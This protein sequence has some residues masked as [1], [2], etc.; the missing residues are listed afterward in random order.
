[1][2][3]WRC[4]AHQVVDAIRDAPQAGAVHLLSN[5]ALR[6]FITKIIRACHSALYDEYVPGNTP[7]KYL[8][9]M[10]EFVHGESGIEPDPSQFLPQHQLQCK[11]IKDTKRLSSVDAIAAFNGKFQYMSCWAKSDR[12]NVYFVI[13]AISL[14]NWSSLSSDD[15]RMAQGCIGSYQSPSNAVPPGASRA[16]EMIEYPYSYLR[17]LDPFE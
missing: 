17:P 8:T 7:N 3:A 11:K 1:M 13:F 2:S 14:Y 12:K 4:R 5:I 6:P 10:K 16:I 9:P 15:P